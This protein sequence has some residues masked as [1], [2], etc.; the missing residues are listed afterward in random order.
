MR[1][2]LL[3]HGFQEIDQPE[4]AH[5][6][7]V[8]SCTVTH[9]SDRKTLYYIRRFRKTNPQGKIV[10]TGCLTEN[11]DTHILRTRGA[12]IILRNEHKVHVAQRILD[13]DTRTV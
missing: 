7:I 1:E 10:V 3:L 4:Q 6:V 11:D 5:Y 13:H 8:N 9:H 12:D 2:N